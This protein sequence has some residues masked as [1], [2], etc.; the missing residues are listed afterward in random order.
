MRTK[1]NCIRLTAFAC[2]LTLSF[3]AAAQ[4]RGFHIT[5]Y[6]SGSTSEDIR[7]SCQDFTLTVTEGASPTATLGAT[8]NSAAW[9]TATT[10]FNLEPAVSVNATDSSLTWNGTGGTGFVAT[11]ANE[12]V[13]TDPTTESL[14][15]VANC[16]S[17]DTT[18]RATLRLDTRLKNSSGSLAVK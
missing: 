3:G 8:C 7:Y 5:L 9:V 18:D 17:D 15:L 11:C 4:T 2:L 6:D 12:K 10:S 1:A 16:D 14:L 13:A